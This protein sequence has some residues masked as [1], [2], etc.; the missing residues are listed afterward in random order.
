MS[1]SMRSDSPAS[2]NVSVPDVAVAP[3]LPEVA[4]IAEVLAWATRELASAGVAD[5]RNE[6]RRLWSTLV[7]Q[8]VGAAWLGRHDPAEA[9]HIRR[10]LTAVRRRA[11]GMPPAYAAG[12]AAFRTLDLVSDDR[13]LI[14]RPETEGLVDHVLRWTAGGSGGVVADVGTGSGCIAL[15]L[16]V[17]G[18]FDRV[19]AIDRSPAALVLAREN[20]ARVSPLTPVDLCR[21]D[22]V[23]PLATHRCRVIVANPPYLRE[24]EWA[25]LDPAVRDFEPADALVSGADGLTATR[26][27]LQQATGALIANGLLALEIDERRADTVAAYARDTGWRDVAIHHDLFGRPRY[28][29]AVVR[30]DS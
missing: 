26:T 3:A 9:S 14:P 6:A 30:E 25:T 27:L 19:V 21:G 11:T 29:L 15:S 24:D 20:L 1:L 16:A 22:W 4:T 7:D 18:K 5:A 10:F 2:G 12:R 23:E 28:L 8:A 13:A 17:E